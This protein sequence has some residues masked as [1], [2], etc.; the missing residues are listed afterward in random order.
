VEPDTLDA[1]FLAVSVP[2]EKTQRIRD[3]IHGLIVFEAGQPLDQLA[4]RL[5]NAREFSGFAG[6]ASSDSPS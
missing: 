3:P 1:A 5:I 4:W 6:C 2:S